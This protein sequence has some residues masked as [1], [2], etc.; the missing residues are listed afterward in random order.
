MENASKALAIAEGVLIS[1]LVIGALLLMFNQLSDYQKVGEQNEKEVQMIEFNNQFT[2]YLRNKVRGNEVLSLMN[3]VVDYNTRKAENSQEKYQKIKL[4]ITGIQVEKLK[5]DN[6]DEKLIETQYTQDNINNLLRK[7]KEL[8]SKYQL[9][10]ISTLC[11]NITKVM[12]SQ[13]QAKEIL[14][15]DVANYGGYDR[16][17]KDTALYYQYSQFKRLYF[18]C[19]ESATK[20]DEKTGRISEMKLICTNRLD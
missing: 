17:K 18:D 7:V 20:Y 14:Q 10:K 8:E 12:D 11:S 3:R 4:T 9:N 16:V 15:K 6:N 13:E 2:T 1:L 19:D 5:Y